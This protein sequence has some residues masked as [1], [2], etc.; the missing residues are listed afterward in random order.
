MRQDEGLKVETAQS[1][2]R[3]RGEDHVHVFGSGGHLQVVLDE[4]DD[5]LEVI[6]SASM[7]GRGF[8][9]SP[10]RTEHIKRE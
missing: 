3:R 6:A 10:G 5:A 8:R 7:T 4:A 9:L 1:C 2:E